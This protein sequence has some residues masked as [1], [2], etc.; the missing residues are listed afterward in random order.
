M[1]LEDLCTEFCTQ[2]KNGILTN[3]ISP[4]NEEGS[5]WTSSV[6]GESN[7]VRPGLRLFRLHGCASWFYHH[8]GDEHIYYHRSEAAQQ[9]VRNLCAMYPGLERER[10]AG[11]HGHG[12]RAFYDVLQACELIVFIGFS[13][14]DDDVMHVLLKALSERRGSLKVLVVDNMYTAHNVQSRLEDAA[15]RS[16]FHTYVPKD[17]EI[18]VLRLGFGRDNNFDISILDEC[19]KLLKKEKQK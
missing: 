3:G 4:M 5:M 17:K 6:F 16:T 19:N 11:P 14:R 10:G 2:A 12:F 15:R 8:T 7:F 13:F 9:S 1:L 18:T